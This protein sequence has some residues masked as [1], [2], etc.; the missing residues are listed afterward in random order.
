MIDDT[1]V[2]QA[3]PIEVS[4]K[5]FTHMKTTSRLALLTILPYLLP[6]ELFAWFLLPPKR[7]GGGGGILESKI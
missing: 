7:W 2:N 1:V 4:L 3:L 5:A 6:S